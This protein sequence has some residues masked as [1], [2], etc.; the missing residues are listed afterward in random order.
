MRNPRSKVNWPVKPFAGLKMW[1]L[2]GHE[3]LSSRVSAFL[4]APFRHFSGLKMRLLKGH[5]TLGLRVSGIHRYFGGLQ[6][7]FLECH[8]FLAWRILSFLWANDNY[9][10]WF[11]RQLKSFTSGKLT[12]WESM[13]GIYA[14]WID[15]ARVVRVSDQGYV[16]TDVSIFEIFFILAG[17]ENLGSMVH[18]FM[19]KPFL[20]FGGLK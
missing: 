9:G 15:L 19:R 5:D 8:G 7:W 2:R 16:V 14:V 13:F 17:S 3:L 12:T 10:G 4:R 6:M 11:L 18:G 20:D 1:F